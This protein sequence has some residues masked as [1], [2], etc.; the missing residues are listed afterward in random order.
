MNR[1]ALF[2]LLLALL[3]CWSVMGCGSAEVRTMPEAGQPVAAEPGEP[4]LPEE[5]IPGEGG[6]A[7]PAEQP[8]EASTGHPALDEIK[9]DLDLRGRE[10]YE[11]SRHYYLV[12]K[13]YF[14]R[15]E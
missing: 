12:G 11:L 15:N 14:D 13:A 9:K 2:G 3:A 6:E 10:R 8:E 4:V 1:V 5:P 7:A